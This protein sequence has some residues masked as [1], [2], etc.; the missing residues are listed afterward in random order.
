MSL[1]FEAAQARVAAWVSQYEEGYF[2]PL[3]QIARLAEELGELSRAIS[4]ETGA[5][6]PKPGECLHDADEEIGDMLF[7][8]VCLANARGADL[9]EIFSKT[10]AKIE[11]RDADRW[12]KKV[13][14]GGE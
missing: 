12:T 14:N 9:G 7:V 13:R 2:P 3:A 11:K 5:K 4:H 6:K 8:L 10:L 1:T